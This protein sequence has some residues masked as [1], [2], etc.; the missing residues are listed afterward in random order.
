MEASPGDHV[1]TELKFDVG[2]GFAIPDLS[3][4]SGGLT[5]SEPETILLTAT[6]FDTP[7]QR[8][9]AARVTLRR[10]TGGADEGWH[11]KL[12]LAG[13]SRRELHEPLGDEDTVPA[14]FA[15]EV[16][17]WTDGEPLCVVAHMRTR[18]TVRNLVTA[19]G[20]TAAE[21]ADDQVEGQART[22]QQG[23]AERMTWREVEIEL[24]RGDAGILAAAGD[25]LIAAGARPSGS[26][27]KLARLLGSSASR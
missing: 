7:G 10:R 6:Y 23:A 4:V 12:P 3:G 25:A 20:T 5:V 22:P 11:L 8:L 13:G 21:L 27:S 24:V 1:E 26:G 15:S 17:Q 16:S 18:R 2:P 14:R 19:D 9:A